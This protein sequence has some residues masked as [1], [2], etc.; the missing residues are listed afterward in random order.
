MTIAQ[1]QFAVANAQLHEM[2]L[3]MEAADDAEI[4]ATRKMES[5]KISAT[6]LKDQATQLED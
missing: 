2:S 4:V 6:G 3:A 1:Q 5:A